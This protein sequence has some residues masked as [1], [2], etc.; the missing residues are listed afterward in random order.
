MFWCL[1]YLTLIVCLRFAWLV[2]INMDINAHESRKIR[3]WFLPTDTFP[4]LANRSRISSFYP[5]HCQAALGWSTIP[6]G[7]SVSPLGDFY[8]YIRYPLIECKNDVTS[9]LD[10]T[11]ISPISTC[12]D[13]IEIIKF[14]RNM[15]LWSINDV[16]SHMEGLYFLQWM[17]VKS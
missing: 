9:H 8:Q 3:Y 10:L 14:A 17:L 15:F 12:T 11:R 2:S 7:I 16:W 1:G 6:L 5:F 13:N 4:N